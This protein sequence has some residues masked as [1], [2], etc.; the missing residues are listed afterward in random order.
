MHSKD[1]RL[2]RR[3][4]AGDASLSATLDDYAFLCDGSIELYETDFDA[5]DLARARTLAD[6]MITYCGDDAGGFFLA[7]RG[8]DELPL[9]RKDAYD[10]AI[11][12]GNS[13]AAHAL[14][15]LARLTGETKYEERAHSILRA[16]SRDIASQ[17]S[18][19]TQMLLALDHSIGPA[20]EVVIAGKRG[21]EDTRTLL[22]ALR[23]RFTPNVTVLLKLEDDR[24]IET[25][26]PWVA[27]YHAVDGKAAAYVCTNFTCQSPVTDA[28]ALLHMLESHPGAG[29]AR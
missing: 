5:R 9:A 27:G 4:R 8:N 25:L 28:A 17:P 13:V 10:G 14:L 12:S 15:R 20:Y 11:P 2:L 1:G 21:A 19:H 7:P 22:G 26:A 3:Y 18:A 16:F 23:S 6:E 29:Q 24:S